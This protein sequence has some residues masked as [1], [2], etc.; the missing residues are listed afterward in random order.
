MS[1]EQRLDRLE[2]ILLLVVKAGARERKAA[3]GSFK[4]TDEKINALID[5]QMRHEEAYAGFKNRTDEAQVR[6]DEAMAHLA[7][8]QADT[9]E[10]LRAFIKNTDE[11]LNAFIVNTDEK[12][13]AF[14]GAVDRLVNERRE[15]KS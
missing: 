13:N 6:T 3:R 15:E 12:L 5:A 11:K 10:A 7:R 2:R 4:E 9:A 14:I 1:S 8:A